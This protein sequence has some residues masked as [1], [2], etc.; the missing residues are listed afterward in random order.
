MA[1]HEELLAG[2]D[3]ATT[4]TGPR[5]ARIVTAAVTVVADAA[6]GYWAARG[7]VVV[8]NAPL[9]PRTPATSQVS[10]AAAWRRPATCV[11]AGAVR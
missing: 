4:G 5:T 1:W 10:P 8:C 6:R 11:G 7:P 9:Y 3:R 2:F